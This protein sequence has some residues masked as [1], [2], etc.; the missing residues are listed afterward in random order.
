MLPSSAHDH[1]QTRVSKYAH[2]KNNAA[3]FCWSQLVK[4]KKLRHGRSLKQ[5]HELCRLQSWDYA[6][7]QSE[8]VRSWR[9]YM[10][11]SR[12]DVSPVFLKGGGP[13]SCI[14][15]FAISR[16]ERSRSCVQP[17]R[18]SGQYETVSSKGG[19]STKALPGDSY[20]VPFWV[21]Y[22]IP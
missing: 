17:S 6:A 14:N 9:S 8:R 13:R 18:N 21:V 5:G 22:Y 4:R 2:A 3:P 11:A 12:H 1:C 16:P 10:G 19:Q 15:S 7:R 20:A